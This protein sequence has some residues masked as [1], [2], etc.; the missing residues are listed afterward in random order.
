MALELLVVD[1]ANNKKQKKTV[2]QMMSTLYDDQ[3]Y[4]VSGS[5]SQF[6]VTKTFDVNSKIDVFWNGTLMDEGDDY[7][8]N[9]PSNRID[10]NYSLPNS[11]KVMIRVW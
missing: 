11:A 9:V 8:R 1:T 6:V 3:K 7:T 10:F 4:T 5:Q 2:A